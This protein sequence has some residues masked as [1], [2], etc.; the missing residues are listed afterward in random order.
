[1]EL[2]ET[3]RIERSP[4]DVFE[5]WARI[6]RAG[7]H[8]PAIIERTKLTAG[9]IGVGSRFRAVDHWPG[10]D[11]AYTVEITAF[12]R[13][14]RIA[15]TWSNP[16]SGGWDAIFDPLSGGT[17]MRF[18]ATLHPSG[19]HGLALRALWPW[20]ERQVRA[21]LDDFRASLERESADHE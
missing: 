13:P 8:H 12:E 21:F 7:R 5:A 11:V 1:V 3:I 18:H 14:D 9:A 6:D 20:Y 2:N 19:L 15:A 17:A 16:I 4:P 10:L